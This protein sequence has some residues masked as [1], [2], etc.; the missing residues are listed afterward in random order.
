[1][2]I[3]KLLTL[4][5]V[6]F[7]FY[8][9]AAGPAAAQGVDGLLLTVN[10]IGDSHDASPGDRI[11]ANPG[12]SCSLRAAIEESNAGMAQNAIIFDLGQTAVIDLMLGELS[13][14]NSIDILGPGA[15]R[16]TVR[17]SAAPGTPNFRI[18]HAAAGLMLTIRGITITN[19]KAAAGGAILAESS[20]Y[21]RVYDSAVSGNHAG[22]GGA[23]AAANNLYVNRCL[24]DSNIADDRGGAISNTIGGTRPLT[25]FIS[26]TFTGNSA[27]SA[28]AIDNDGTVLLVNA[29]VS[30][31]S[32]T[33]A[34]S[35][36]RNAASGTINV[37]NTIIGRDISQSVTALDG[38]FQ[39]AGN[40]IVT[41]S[42]GS[43]GFTHGTNSDQ[44]SVNNAIDPLLGPLTDNGGQTNTLAL[45]TG[46]P[47]IDNGNVCSTS[48]CPQLPGMFFRNSMD[49]RRSRRILFGSSIDVGAFAARTAITSPNATFGIS[50][51][52]LGQGARHQNSIVI[53]MDATTL[54]KHYSVLRPGGTF[55][56]QGLPLGAVFV[57]EIRAK[58]SGMQTPLVFALD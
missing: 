45:L 4:A 24:F 30:G 5:T 15:R 48:Q 22:T 18:F 36:I 6:L 51:S 54:E 44:V 55:S 58:R 32:A 14:I 56:F 8:I 9:Y 52:G 28:G 49:Q 23:I 38:T 41:D 40:N 12:G 57:V 33:Q 39:S 35:S 31:N 26:S 19:G 27:S 53:I 50:F 13:V 42:R 21:V 43:T 17:R 47:A 3:R 29:T 46:S 34:A 1:M 2:K 11:C 25:T 16:L 37:L 7:A 20:A 10:S